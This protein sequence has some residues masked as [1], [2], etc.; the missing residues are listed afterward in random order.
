MALTDGLVPP[1]AARD[2][3]QRLIESVSPERLAALVRQGELRPRG[4]RLDAQKPHA[5]RQWLL[6]RLFSRSEL[7]AD[8]LKLLADAPEPARRIVAL[9]DGSLLCQVLPTIAAALGARRV[10]AA[11][12]VDPRPA[13]CAMAPDCLALAPDADAADASVAEA[14]SAQLQSLL[15][16]LG[17]LLKP[18]K[19]SDSAQDVAPQTNAP[20]HAVRRLRAVEHRLATL[21]SERTERAQASQETLRA[22]DAL[23]KQCRVLEQQRSDLQA[24]LDQLREATRRQVDEQVNRR[25]RDR[26]HA[27]M[28]PLET[29]AEALDTKPT[30]LLE[31]ADASLRRQRSRD[32]HSGNRASLQKRREALASARQ[33]IAE[34]RREALNPLP[35]L[36]PLETELQHAID[37]LDRLLGASPAAPDGIAARLAA[38]INAAPAEA[39]PKLQELLSTLQTLELCNARERDALTARLTRRQAHLLA[40]A[41]AP[42]LPKDADRHAPTALLHEALAGRVGL[43]LLID[44]HNALFALRARY[45]SGFVDHAPGHRARDQLIADLA[46]L[47][48]DHPDLRARLVFDGPERSDRQVSPNLTVT[49][50]GGVGEDRADRVLIEEAGFLA[51]SPGRHVVVVSNDGDVVF[52]SRGYGVRDM[53]PAELASFFDRNR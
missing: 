49:Y 4:F 36:A 43:D 9:L 10:A 13:V 51:R 19:P 22:L 33:Q 2:A 53:T 42:S 6:Q 8:A 31:R 20:A 3:L 27:W 34:A 32:R 1:A 46:G 48:R 44:A 16:P 50:S 29:I 25:L 35:E 37:H 11:L 45:E 7:P 12:L 47:V 5:L 18:P 40:E 28:M 17:H 23:R 41:P 26:A 38:H 14:A 52:R 24:D 15:A 21:Q 30:D 39:L